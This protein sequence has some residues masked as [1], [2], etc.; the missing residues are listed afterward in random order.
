MSTRALEAYPRHQI[1][2]TLYNSGWPAG[3][4]AKLAVILVL[5]TANS[6]VEGGF[7]PLAEVGADSIT[8]TDSAELYADRRYL[9]RG[10]ARVLE[11][12]EPLR[13]V[14]ALIFAGDM[15]AAQAVRTLQAWI[16]AT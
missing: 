3:V 10:F 16:V 11:R 9:D 7:P 15:D 5:C 12:V 13:G 1:A 4:E 6:P 8:L 2:A 14:L